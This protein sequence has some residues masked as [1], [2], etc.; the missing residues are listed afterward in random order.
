[1]EGVNTTALKSTAL[2]TILFVLPI[3][4]EADEI[5]IFFLIIPIYIICLASIY[6][7]IVPF[8]HSE[9]EKLS[10]EGIFNKYF[11]YYA[12]VSFGLC[13]FI[14][15]SIYDEFKETYIIYFFVSAFFTAMQSWVWLF[16]YK[17]NK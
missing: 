6:I 2:A 7:T 9:K 1:M 15:Y 17:K 10:N 11:P 8:Y 12:L 13:V 16:K 3:F 4:S 14:T 5:G